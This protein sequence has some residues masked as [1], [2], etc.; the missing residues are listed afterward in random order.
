MGK[1]L[2]P[3]C[4]ALLRKAKQSVGDQAT[5]I[6]NPCSTPRPRGT[7]HSDEIFYPERDGGGCQC[8]KRIAMAAL[9]KRRNMAKCPAC[10]HEVSIFSGKGGG[11]RGP[12]DAKV[13]TCHNCKK[14][15]RVMSIS[16]LVLSIIIIA[17]LVLSLKTPLFD[18]FPIKV[19]IVVLGIVILEFWLGW[20]YVIKLKIRDERD[21]FKSFRLS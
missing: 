16:E 15:L 3:H 7:L 14:E 9:E 19:G 20:R 4:F 1:F 8:N 2:Y 6:S 5:K 11:A 17:T 13:F 10:N 12:W 18:R 21:N